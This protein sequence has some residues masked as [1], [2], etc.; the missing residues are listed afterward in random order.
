M[1]N[2]VCIALVAALL[3]PVAVQGQANE[4]AIKKQLA[5]LS[6]YGGMRGGPP[7]MA[8]ADR[9]AA[10]AKLSKDIAS[11]PPG[12]KKVEDADVLAVISTQG[13]NGVESMQAAADTLAAALKESPQPAAKDGTPAHP[14]MELAKMAR[15]AGIKTSLSDP[16]LDVAAKK[17]LEDEADVQKADFT[18]KDV[19]GKK[20]TLSALKGKIVLVNFFATNC[21][22]CMHE[23]Q[24]L[25]LIHEHYANQGLVILR[26]TEEN[27]AQ[28]Y[29]IMSHLN[30]KPQVLLDNGGMGYNGPAGK[31]FHVDGF[32]R[33]FVFDREGKLAAESLDMCS[34]QQFFSMLGRAGLQPEQH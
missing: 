18:L 26:I 3:A 17:V 24:D 11:L 7:A 31:A 5:A 28:V 8:D 34:Q 32:P 14:Y 30:F 20:V 21:S 29:K 22:A 9:A 10:I 13:Q 25:E 33:T 19:D 16:Q 4:G 23:T 2:R 1:M 6:F 12:T 15:Y 27:P